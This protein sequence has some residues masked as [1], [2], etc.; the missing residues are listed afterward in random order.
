M[1]LFGWLQAQFNRSTRKSLGRDQRDAAYRDRSLRLERLEDRFALTCAAAPCWL[2]VTLTTTDMSGAPI[3][4]IPVGSDFQLQATVSDVRVFPDG[5]EPSYPPTAPV[6]TFA[7][8]DDVTFDPSHVAV[9]GAISYGSLF[10]N[11]RTPDAEVFATPGLLDEIGAV[12]DFSTFFTGTPSPAL[13]FSVPFTANAAGD[14][15]FVLDP[16]DLVRVHDSLLFGLN[17]AVPVDK[18]DFVNA[19][20]HV[21]SLSTQ[22]QINLLTEQVNALV[23]SDVLNEGNGNALISKLDNAASSFTNSNNTAGANQIEAF[24]HQVNALVN[25]G[26]LTDA[27]GQSLIDAA[28]DII[29]SALV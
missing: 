12:A 15:N 9:D 24:I 18:I 8:Y 26:K 6:G 14:V 16:A 17:S 28:D 13:L 3:T 10:T 22:D 11:V 23:S 21:D 19:T 25:S 4:S 20:I 1:S 27:Q 7:S 2:Q 5:F 29:A